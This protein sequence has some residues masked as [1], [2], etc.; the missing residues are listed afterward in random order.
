[1]QLYDPKEGVILKYPGFCF[2]RACAL[3]DGMLDSD[4]FTSRRFSVNET[5]DTTTTEESEAETDEPI[6]IV[7]TK[8]LYRPC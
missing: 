7:C 5:A 1:L 2:V 6:D 8:R 4:L 3:Y